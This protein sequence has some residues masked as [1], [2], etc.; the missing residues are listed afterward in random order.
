[1]VRKYK[2]GKI[3][4]FSDARRLGELIKRILDT[5]FNTLMHYRFHVGNLYRTQSFPRFAEFRAAELKF[6][7][8]R[9]ILILTQKFAEN[10]KMTLQSRVATDSGR[11]QHELTVALSAN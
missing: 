6:A 9:G 5:K 10:G 8:N 3:Y 11:N 2:P 1:V 4:G 7:I